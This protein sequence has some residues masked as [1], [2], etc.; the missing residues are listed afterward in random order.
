MRHSFSDI[1]WQ[2]SEDEYRSN[3][4]LSY[5]TLAKFDRTGFSG[6][7]KLTEH[8]DTPSLTFGSCVDAIITG[9]YDEF[10]DRFYVADDNFAE[11]EDKEI[12][13]TKTLFNHFSSTIN[14]IYEIPYN[15][16]LMEVLANDYHKN[17]RE[18][19][20]VKVIRERCDK[21]YACLYDAKN[22]TII[23]ARTYEDVQECVTALKESYYTGQFFNN[24]DDPDIEHYYQLKFKSTLHN[25]DYRVM[26]DLLVVNHRDKTVIPV[27]LKTSSHVEWEF[28]KSF[29]EWG[30]AHQARLYYRVIRDNMN[31]DSY[32]KDFEL[33]DYRFI[34]VNKTTLTPLVWLCPFTKSK[35]E[36]KF[37]RNKQIIIRDPEDLGNEL[38]LYLTQEHTVP[39]NINQFD[40]NNLTFFLYNM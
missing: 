18:D 9:G 25:I 22:K 30:Y 2:V 14:T 31:K 24:S 12:K 29:V 34:V 27:D 40:D 37:G 6:L 13:I 39:L 20:R 7:S 5:S 1:S 35:G 36:L 28:Y 10:N 16:V 33:L 26:A 23:D 21:Y 8:I 38:N 19:T 11:L 17:W 3:P 4:A 15:D 32:F